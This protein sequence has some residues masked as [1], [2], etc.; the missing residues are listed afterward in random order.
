MLVDLGSS[1]TYPFKNSD[2]GRSGT[3]VVIGSLLSVVYVLI[4]P[5]LLIKGYLCRVTREAARGADHHLP[6]W[7]DMGTLLNQGFQLALA[8]LVYMFIPVSLTLAGVGG[9]VAGVL[10]GA[11]NESVASVVAGLGFMAVLGGAGLLLGFIISFVL[12]MVQLKFSVSGRLSSAFDLRGIMAGIMAG[13]FDYLLI[14]AVTLGAGM[15]AAVILSWILPG[16]GT[17]LQF[18]LQ[19]YLWV[20]MSHMMGQYYR[21]HLADGA[22]KPEAWASE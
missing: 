6:E 11:G 7:D 13:F 2:E 9:A 8:W 4:I 15:I 1:F 21:S 20:V 16:L 19:F 14:W 18:P 3:K 10:W 5:A 17:V 12:P 22:D